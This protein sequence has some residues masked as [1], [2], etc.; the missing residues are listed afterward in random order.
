[1]TLFRRIGFMLLLNVAVMI[2]IQILLQFLGLNDHSQIRY[3]SARFQMSS[4]L[5][6]CFIW[7]MT[8]SFISLF[9]SKWMAKTLMQVRVISAKDGTHEA[10]LLEMVKR[11][12]RKAEL[13]TPPEVGIYESDQI[14]AFATGPSQNNA[15]VAVSSGLLRTLSR[16]QVEGV[17]GHEIAHIA[18]GDM[19]TMTLLQGIINSFT[20]FFSY[21]LSTMIT[22]FLFR[23]EKNSERRHPFVEFFVRQILEVVFML[24]GTL[25]ICWFSRLRE[26]RAD[27]GGSRFAGKDKMISALQGLKRNHPSSFASSPSA[28][29]AL[30]ISNKSSVWALFSTHP[31]LDDRIERLTKGRF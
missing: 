18:N 29:Q 25:V 24:L 9:L 22:Q 5:T 11:L 23:N 4:L 31:G 14:N 28:F 2:T 16:D 19:V 20:L 10:Q 15:L 7:G 27:A 21:I 26:Y 1:M 30:Q 6:Y 13:A 12:S 8:G 17:L 3:G